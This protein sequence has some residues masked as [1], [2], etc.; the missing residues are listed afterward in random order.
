[1]SI[2]RLQDKAY[3]VDGNSEVGDDIGNWFGKVYDLLKG[4]R[5]EQSKTE[6]EEGG[7]GSMPAS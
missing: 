5:A 7:I 4:Q 6:E 1:V 3:A 2:I